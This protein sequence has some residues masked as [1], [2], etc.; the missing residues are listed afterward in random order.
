MSSKSAEEK[1]NETDWQVSLLS[2][3]A[4]KVYDS[5][6]WLLKDRKQTAIWLDDAQLSRRARVLIQFIP[7]AQSELA[8]SGLM[9]MEPGLNQ[10]KYELVTSEDE[11]EQ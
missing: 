4:Q 7:G 8:K 10:V 11:A 5:I 6:T 1:I 2:E 9:H 3:N